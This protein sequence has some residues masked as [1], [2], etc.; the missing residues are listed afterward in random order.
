MKRTAK[1]ARPQAAPPRAIRR[2]NKGLS[3]REPGKARRRWLHRTGW[4]LVIQ[5]GR[6][7]LAAQY[8][9]RLYG[10][11]VGLHNFGIVSFHSACSDFP[12]KDLTSAPALKVETTKPASTEARGRVFP[13]QPRPRGPP[14]ADQTFAPLR[15]PSER[16][17]VGLD[18]TPPARRLPGQPQL[19]GP[20]QAD[21]T[22]D[23]KA[24]SG[25]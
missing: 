2:H 9:S 10:L 12:C 8:V 24:R 7:H 20:P 21:Q 3:R 22:F 18:S 11:G 17:V 19:R 6:F 16:R 14:Q 25:G 4:H 23:P 13:G 1:V 5:T 15:A